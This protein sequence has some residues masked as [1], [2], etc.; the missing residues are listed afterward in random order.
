MRLP[1]RRQRPVL[2][3]GLPRS[4][5]TWVGE[6]LGSAAGCTYRHE[7]MTQ[8][9]LRQDGDAFRHVPA[10]GRD[11]EVEAEADR[12]FAPAGRDRL[13]VKE[14]LP[15]LGAWFAARPERPVLVD[16]VRHPVAVAASH[17]RLGWDPA[18]RERDRLPAGP[19]T[20]RLH[21]RWDDLGPVER[22]VAYVA[23]V[24]AH[25]RA[26]WGPDAIHV[27]HEDLLADPVAGYGA[28]GERLGLRG[29]DLE[30]RNDRPG[31]FSL[32]RTPRPYPPADATADLREL[33]S[34]FGPADYLD[35]ADWR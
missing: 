31:P 9:L 26:T 16:L 11:A 17:L 18:P 1:G 6:V 32:D 21:A 12:A 8:A 7:P 3:L 33:W 24:R 25:V 34:S 23:A 15:L 19:A 5:S 4:G 35:D 2:V 20:E 14:V 13:V 27:R 22:K 10:G 30:V 28:L 29:L